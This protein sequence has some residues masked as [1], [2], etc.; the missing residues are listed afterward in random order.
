MNQVIRV[1]YFFEDVAH[2]RFVRALVHRVAEEYH[3]PIEDDVRN[4]TQGSRVRVELRRFIREIGS[5][6]HKPCPEMLVVVIDG[7]CRGVSQVRREIL[8]E[9]ERSGA[10]IAHLVFAI[11]N[12]HIERWYLEDQQAWAQVLPGAKA[13]KIK[14]K[15]ERDRYKNELKKAIRAAGV[16]PLLGGAEYGEEIA[17]ALSP[18]QLDRSFQ[19]FWR[20][21]KREFGLLANE[22]RT[23][24][25]GA[26]S[27]A[28]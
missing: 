3:V 23:M 6:S 14:Y 19:D 25:H 24:K 22:T 1:V 8:A 28:R 12:P 17:K 11:P 18:Q 13:K 20:D 26:Q 10:T 9:I 4:A 2:E 15:C 21:L 7:N 27:E 5:R 16:E